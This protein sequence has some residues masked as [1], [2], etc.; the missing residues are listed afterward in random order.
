M[1]D[2]F[3]DRV[4]VPVRND[5]GDVVGFI[6]RYDGKRDDVPKYLNCAKTISYDKSVNLYRP[7]QRPLDPYAQ[8]VIREGTLDALAIAACARLST[9]CTPVVE[10]DLAISDV[11]WNTILA[12]HDRAL[13]LC[14]DGDEPGREDNAQ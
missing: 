9:K 8:V 3:R 4:M 2:A 6:G 7:S 5:A 14:V 12:I 11:Q 1:I 13:V 10:S